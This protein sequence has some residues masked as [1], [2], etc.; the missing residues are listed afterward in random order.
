MNE[1]NLEI[2]DEGYAPDFVNL[3]FMLRVWIPAQGTTAAEWRGRV[4]SLPDGEAFYYCD[5]PV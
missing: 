2:I 1:G 5:W 3:V 4:Q